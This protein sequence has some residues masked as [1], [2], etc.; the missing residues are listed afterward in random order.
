[1]EAQ[2]RTGVTYSLGEIGTDATSST[3]SNCRMAVWFVSKLFTLGAKIC[4]Q[5]D[6][7]LEKYIRNRKDSSFAFLKGV[8]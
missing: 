8:Y 5:L 1:L 7:E 6:C 3:P 2:L 4:V